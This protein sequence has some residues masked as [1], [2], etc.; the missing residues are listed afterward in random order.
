MKTAAR[1]FVSAFLLIAMAGAACAQTTIQAESLKPVRCTEG[2]VDP[3]NMVDFNFAKP[4]VFGGDIVAHWV[5]MENPGAILEYRIPA[6]AGRYR[7]IVGLAKSWDYGVYQFMID[8]K[9][10][11]GRIDMATGGAPEVVVPAK[12]DLGVHDV[13]GEHILLAARFIGESPR[14]KEGPN[15]KSMAIDYVQLAPVAGGSAAER[16]GG[17]TSGG[18]TGGGVLD[19]LKSEAEKLLGDVIGSKRVPP[20]VESPTSGQSGKS[21][22]GSKTVEVEKLKPVRCTVGSVDPFNM[23]DFNLA[24]PGVFGGDTV[25]HWVG[26]EEPGGILEYRIPVPAPGRYRVI[27]G[28]A[29]SWDYGVY[30]FMIDGKNVGSRVDMAT[31]GEPEVVVPFKLDL[32][33]ADVKSEHILL[34]ARFVGES[35]KAKEGPNP[36]SMAMDYV[37]LAPAGAGGGTTGGGATGGGGAA[38]SAITFEIEKLTIIKTSEGGA[39]EVNVVELGVSKPREFGADIVV[40][41]AGMENAGAVLEFKVPVAV[42]GR[43]RVTVGVA[44]S[45]D[46][47]T[48]QAMINGEDAGSPMDLASQKEPEHT[49]P[50][51][52]NLGVHDLKRPQFTLGFRFE[53]ASPNAQDGPNPMSGAFDWVRLTPV[54]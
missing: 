53:G 12:A 10:V 2:S 28:L 18:R 36:R 15:P 25:A 32:G 27:V 13:R 50:H 5:G 14:A 11:G 30:Q 1:A 42:A 45:W 16:G 21:A 19:K 46:Y 29:K 3:F 54:R 31:G 40:H 4:G 39:G 35:P 48:Y 17:K 44:K 33:I 9:D 24:K 37:Q 41:W 34:A 23:V 38:G 20:T 52:V 7:V 43:Y 51:V 8:G 49:Y 26:M 47:G 6:A 22:P